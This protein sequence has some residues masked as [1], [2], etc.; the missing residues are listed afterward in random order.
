[1]RKN[2]AEITS[3]Y[4]W[5]QCAKALVHGYQKALGQHDKGEAMLPLRKAG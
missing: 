3:I 1:M 5:K 2:T 4:T